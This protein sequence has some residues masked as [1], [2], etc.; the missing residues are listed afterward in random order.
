VT[1][2]S[3]ELD[4][5]DLRDI[6]QDLS[7]GD[8]VLPENHKNLVQALVQ[9]HAAG[10][11]IKQESETEVFEA[12]LVRGKGSLSRHQ[13]HGLHVTLI[14]ISG[15]MALL[16]CIGS[17]CIILLHGEPGVGKTSTAGTRAH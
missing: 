13:N 7:W 6:V 8:L 16:T 4:I 11:G 5:N 12:D 3:V 15:R 9:T 17:G 1:F 14:C 2:C 10:S